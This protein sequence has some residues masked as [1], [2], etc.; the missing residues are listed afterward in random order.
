[1]RFA[2]NKAKL[3]MEEVLPRILDGGFT[4]LGLKEGVPGLGGLLVDLEEMLDLFE[5]EPLHGYTK[6]E[7]KRLLRV[8]DP[9]VTYLVNRGFIQSEKTRHPRSRRPMSIVPEASYTAFLDRFVTFGI[10]ALQIGTQAKHVSSKLE[11]LKIDPIKLAPRFSKIYERR[12]LR[13]VIESGGWVIEA[14]PSVRS[15]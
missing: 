4:W 2:C 8:N 7:L 9:T 15:S 12:L 1:M 5:A 3:T 10:L 11:K 13:S 6:Q 14:F